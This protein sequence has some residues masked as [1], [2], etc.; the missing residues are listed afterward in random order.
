MN[1]Y[2]KMTPAALFLGAALFPGPS[3]WAGSCCGGGGGASL[4]LPKIYNSMIDVSADLEKYDG[5]WN[6]NGTYTADPPDSDLRQYRLNLG[7]AKTACIPVADEYFRPL[8]MEHQQ[9]FRNFSGKTES[10]TRR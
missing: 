5:F 7:Y 1:S 8:C 3:A 2:L 6:Q 10:A 9:L 4:V